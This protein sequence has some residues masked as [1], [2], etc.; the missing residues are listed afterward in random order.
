MARPLPAARRPQWLRSLLKPHQENRRSR[1]RRPFAVVQYVYGRGHGRLIPGKHYLFIVSVRKSHASPDLLNCASVTA[2][3]RSRSSGLFTPSTV[4][5]GQRAIACCPNVFPNEPPSAETSRLF[6]V[7]AK[8]RACLKSL[9]RQS[10][11][12]TDRFRIRHRPF[13]LG[14]GNRSSCPKADG[15]LASEEVG[16]W[17]FAI[18]R[19]RSRPDPHR[20]VAA[21]QG[22]LAA[23]FEPSDNLGD[24]SGR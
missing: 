13:G 18:V 7:D 9:R 6:I 11:T 17:L 21:A 1:A 2:L 5:C 4:D 20:L 8:L 22:L 12:V 23:V 3:V 14:G 24:L 10:S 15:C 19:L 16:R